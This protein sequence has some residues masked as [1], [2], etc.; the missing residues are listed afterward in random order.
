MQICVLAIVQMGVNNVL[1]EPICLGG[2]CIPSFICFTAKQNTSFKSK[3]LSSQRANQGGGDR[4][5][6]IHARLTKADAVEPIYLPRNNQLLIMLRMLHFPQLRS[7]LLLLIRTLIC[8]QSI[9]PEIAFRP[10]LAYR[11]KSRRQT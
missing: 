4:N 8:R 6:L 7:F 5:R 1:L 2:N 10:S 11:H 9:A 3:L